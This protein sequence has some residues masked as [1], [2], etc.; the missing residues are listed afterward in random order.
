MISLVNMARKMVV[1]RLDKDELEYELKYRGVEVGTAEEMRHRLVMTLRLEKSGESFKYPTYPFSFAE[2]YAAIELKCDDLSSR[3]DSLSG[4]PSSSEAVKLETKFSHVLGRLDNMVV[5]DIVDNQ[6]RKATL[7]AKV[8]TLYDSL[9]GKLYPPL[10]VGV[11]VP[12]ALSIIQGA[13]SNQSFESGVVHAP[14]SSPVSQNVNCSLPQGKMVPPH[15]WGLEK[16]SGTSKSLS[17]C[18]FFERVEELRVARHV[19]KEVLL[20]SGIDLF[21]EKAYQFYKDVRSRV[22]CWEELIAEFRCEYLTAYHDD[23]RFEELR[24]RTQHSSESIGVY[25]SIMNSYFRRL[26]CH[27][28]EETKLA[29]VIKNL[30]PF[31]QDRLRDPLPSSLEELRSVCRR[32]EERRDAINSYIEPSG[33]RSGVLEKDLAFVETEE[34]LNKLEVSSTSTSSCPPSGSY[35]IGDKNIVC[36]RCRRLGHRANNCRLPRK[37]YC[38]KCNLEGYTVK[39]CPTCNQ[40]NGVKRT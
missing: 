1:G 34:F 7:L 21:S 14:S 12:S 6:T 37:L 39:T 40:G 33:K 9:H 36:F 19:P 8:L 16:F 11:Q 38:F 13:T 18:A 28:L 31:Y 29:I 2:D 24:R 23:A 5:G 10:P 35:N 3:I 4:G 32:M 25:L 22:N 26:T 15:K 27:V 20:E 30:H 17:I